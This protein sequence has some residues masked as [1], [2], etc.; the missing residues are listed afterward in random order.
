MTEIVEIMKNGQTHHYLGQW[1]HC[2][3]DCIWFAVIMNFAFWGIAHYAHCEPL[4]K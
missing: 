2:Y 1:K 3:D 4:N